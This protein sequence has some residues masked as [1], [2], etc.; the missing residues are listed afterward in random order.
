[1]GT[2]FNKNE[3]AR[4]L[5]IAMGDRSINQYALHSSVS[6]TYISKLL[7]ELVE[8][9]PGAVIIK[10]LAEKAQNSILYED[11][12]R[13]AGHLTQEYDTGNMS[14]KF[15]ETPLKYNCNTITLP[16]IDTVTAGGPGPA[17]AI[18]EYID[19]TKDL[20]DGATFALRVQGNSMTDVGIYDGD[21]V[22]VKQQPTAENGQTVLV[23]TDST[24]TIK[25]FYKVDGK[26]RLE[27]ANGAYKPID[28][29]DIE[30]IG[31]V[32]AVTRK[33]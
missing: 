8:K 33:L 25:R 28:P 26:I 18:K 6:A 1:M 17:G 2:I 14:D 12:M 23:R 20:A 11:L 24:V 16:V 15:K 31:I 7:R 9:P 3:F 30:I 13:A 32:Q 10:K 21:F 4:L 5:K 22:V 29:A 19:F 27:P